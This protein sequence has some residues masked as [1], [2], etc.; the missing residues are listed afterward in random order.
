M[1]TRYAHKD[2]YT[3]ENSSVLKNKA[4][5]RDQ[6]ALDKFERLSVA[7][8]MVEDPPNGNF[9]YQHIKAIHRHL[10]QD[11]YDWAG[12][13]RTV[14]ISKGET[15]F[16]NP[17]FI[18]NSVTTLTA[19][20]AQ[21]NHLKNNSPEKFVEQAAYYMLELNVAHPFREGNGRTARYYLSLLA[22]NA[23]YDIDTEKLK[24]G[25]L[26]ACIEGVAGSEQPM[27]DL[28]ASALIVYED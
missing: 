2:A 5:H 8:R 6:E 19:E 7:N 27:C 15:L 13:E 23:G 17:R 9:D 12:E 3:Y 11:V 18:A 14:S 16:C 21:E 24:H 22:H 28:I 4:G 20:L 1:T 10:F 25:W 26:D